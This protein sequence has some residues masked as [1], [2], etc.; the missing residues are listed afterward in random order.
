MKY[1]TGYPHIL[2]TRQFKERVILEELFQTANEMRRRCEEEKPVDIAKGKILISLFYEP[3]TRTRFS[4]ESAMTR[5]GGNYIS[6][7]NAPAFSSAAKGESLEDTIRVVSDYGDIIVLRHPERGSAERAVK[8]ARIPLINAGDGDNQ[9]PT[10]SL[11]DIYTINREIGRIDG[12]KV[13]FMGDNKKSRTV[14]SL[15]YLLA[16]QKQNELYFISPGPL[17]IENDIKDWFKNKATETG[18]K[19]YEIDEPKE[20]LPELDVLYV[21]RLQLE[22]YKDVEGIEKIKDAYNK[23]RLNKEMIN[24]MKSDAIVL[25]PLPRVN[26]IDKEIDSDPRA[27]YFEQSKNGVY[28]RMALIKY[29]IK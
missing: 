12:L 2:D 21:T 24:H 10:Q 5:L 4:F 9:H 28:M 29:I 22:R 8:Y 25:H 3:S 16:Q 13:G 19:F 15:A 1:W 27:R 20:I 26:E 7:E 6:T 14:R 23:F 11:L 18:V 17:N